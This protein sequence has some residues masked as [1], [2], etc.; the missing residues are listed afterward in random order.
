M[1]SP[2]GA[3]SFAFV[4]VSSAPRPPDNER[5]DRDHRVRGRAS[6]GRIRNA[7]AP[8]D[9]P[10]TLRRRAR[11]QRDAR[12]TDAQGEGAGT[13]RAPGIASESRTRLAVSTSQLCCSPK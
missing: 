5:R 9:R 12:K 10:A 4:S 8:H 2:L 1:P 6:L 7:S 13:E 3:N 11:R